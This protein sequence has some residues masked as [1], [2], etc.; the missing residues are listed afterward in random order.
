[1]GWRDHNDQCGSGD[2]GLGVVWQLR[3]AHTDSGFHEPGMISV[4]G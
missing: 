1:V 4:Q 2:D 3:T